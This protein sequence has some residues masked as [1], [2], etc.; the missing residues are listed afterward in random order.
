MYVKWCQEVKHRL[1]QLGLLAM[2]VDKH[3]TSRAIH[4][5][6]TAL[7]ISLIMEEH[8]P[9]ILGAVVTLFGTTLAVA[10]ADVYSE[11]IAANLPAPYWIAYA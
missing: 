5:S 9:T 1:A 11:S 7:A 3:F 10:R 8:P 6:I 2:T 4:Y